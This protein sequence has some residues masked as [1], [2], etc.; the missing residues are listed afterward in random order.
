[1]GI[2]DGDILEIA[3]K[4]NIKNK[5]YKSGNLYVHIHVKTDKNY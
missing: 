3:G 5:K 1:M 4:G 2:R